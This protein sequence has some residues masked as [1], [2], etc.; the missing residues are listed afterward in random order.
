MTSFDILRF[1]GILGLPSSELLQQRFGDNV[2]QLLDP[3]HASILKSAATG[4]PT[5]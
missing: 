4:Q 1:G 5:G 2:G 3:N